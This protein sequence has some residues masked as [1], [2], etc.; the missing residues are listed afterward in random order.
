MFEILRPLS[1]CYSQVCDSS[2]FDSIKFVTIIRPREHLVINQ[3]HYTWNAIFDHPVSISVAP[4]LMTPKIRL[5]S[6]ILPAQYPI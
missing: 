2:R 4:G 5:S 6:H 3:L 1:D